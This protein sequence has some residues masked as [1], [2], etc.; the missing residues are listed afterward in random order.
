MTASKQIIE[1]LDAIGDKLG[2]AID[3]TSENVWPYLKEIMGKYVRYKIANEVFFIIISLL[4]FAVIGIFITK[5]AKQHR[6]IQLSERNNFFWEYDSH[7]SSDPI[8]PTDFTCA[9]IG[10]SIILGGIFVV[11]FFLSISCLIKC[12]TIPEMVVFD[13][14]T[15]L[16]ST[17]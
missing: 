10:G 13:Y 7:L 4:V 1:V 15:D 6:E 17:I 14:V 11:L 8:W 5:C 3:W 2:V 12:F 16:L 9:C